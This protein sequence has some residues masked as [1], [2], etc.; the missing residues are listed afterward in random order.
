M[1]NNSKDDTLDELEQLVCEPGANLRYVTETG[2]GIVPA[3]NRAIEECINVD[4]MLFLDDD[5]LP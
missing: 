3:H 1:N 5:E 4:Y 2:Q